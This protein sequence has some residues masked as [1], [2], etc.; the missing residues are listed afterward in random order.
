MLNGKCKKCK[1]QTENKIILPNPGILL[2][3]ITIR[4]IAF[5]SLWQMYNKSLKRALPNCKHKNCKLSASP[6]EYKTVQVFSFLL[7]LLLI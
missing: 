2:I 5:G 6:V 4:E 1:E 3:L 7:L